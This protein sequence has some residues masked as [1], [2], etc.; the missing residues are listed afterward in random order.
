VDLLTA[1]VNPAEQ[2]TEPRTSI[3]QLAAPDAQAD[4]PDLGAV[5]DGRR[6]T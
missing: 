6:P 1:Y 2:V 5:Q 3:A 4:E